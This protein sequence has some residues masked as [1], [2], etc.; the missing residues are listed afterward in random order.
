MYT[1]VEWA[2]LWVWG[3]SLPLQLHD[4]YFLMRLLIRGVH[5]ATHPLLEG[6]V[7]LD[8]LEAQDCGSMPDAISDGLL[9]VGWIFDVTSRVIASLVV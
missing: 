9:H 3:M 2:T 7:T 4:V 6:R 1:E 5:E 8:L